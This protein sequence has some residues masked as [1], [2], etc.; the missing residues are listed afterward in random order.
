MSNDE[1][2]PKRLPT[3]E[4][5]LAMVLPVERRGVSRVGDQILGNVVYR[6]ATEED[7]NNH[8]KEEARVLAEGRHALRTRK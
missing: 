7:A 1:K 6:Y 4:E 3:R 2:A 5:I 8:L